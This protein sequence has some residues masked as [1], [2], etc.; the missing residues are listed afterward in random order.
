MWV[1]STPTLQKGKNDIWGPKDYAIL[2]TASAIEVVRCL[3]D[4]W[5]QIKGW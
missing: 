4:I 2:K 5:E 3:A 1:L